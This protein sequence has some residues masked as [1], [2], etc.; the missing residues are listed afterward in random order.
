MNLLI[1]A[2]AVYASMSFTGTA[3]VEWE[4]DND[5]E[6]KWNGIFF[7]GLKATIHLNEVNPE[8]SEISASF[9]ADSVHSG[10]DLKDTHIREAFE[11]KKFPEITFKT[12]DISRNYIG[13]VAKG[14]LTIKGVTRQMYLPFKVLQNKE[15]TPFPYIIKKIFRGSLSIMPADFK[16][17]IQGLPVGF[18][19]WLILPVTRIPN[20]PA[21][22]LLN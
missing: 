6:V 22:Q 2:I 11:A 14:N 15:G 18:T 12:T 4:L 19:V 3:P 10:D 16:I 8:R 1:G 20:S 7:R 21:D 13:Y 9:A 5:Y 17:T